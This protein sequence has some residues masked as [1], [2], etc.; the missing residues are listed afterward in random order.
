M[1]FQCEALYEIVKLLGK[2][3][4]V[5]DA[6]ANMSR[7]DRVRVFVELDV[8]KPLLDSFYIVYLGINCKVEVM[9]DYVPIYCA[10]CFKVGHGKESCNV[11]DDVS[12]SLKGMVI[13]TSS[14]M[15][16]IV[17]CHSDSSSGI[18][19]VVE[20]VLT[21]V[22]ILDETNSVTVDDVYEGGLENLE[23]NEKVVDDIEEFPFG[24]DNYFDV[25]IG[26][27]VVCKDSDTAFAHLSSRSAVNH[28]S[29][30]SACIHFTRVLKLM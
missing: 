6:T 11:V 18:D 4:R 7:L 25:E 14:S 28:L 22:T 21:E 17:T 29:S 19:H 5:D 9:Y 2:P 15:D 27:P 3:I 23:V 1:F 8:S 26:D 13:A 24:F 10:I 20:Q 30:E 12:I 16:S